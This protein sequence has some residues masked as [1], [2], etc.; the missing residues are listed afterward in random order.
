MAD[1]DL[2]VAVL[3]YKRPDEL[4][5]G[6]PTIIE[7]VIELNNSPQE[8]VQARILVVDNDPAGTGRAPVDE[9]GSPLLHY[10]LEPQPG[11]S[12]GRNRALRE[13]AHSS[14]LSFIDDDERPEE[15]WLVPLI[16]TWRAT[17]AAAVMGRVVSSFESP[18]D[19][20]VAAG[21]FFRR[22]RMRT[23]TEISVAAAGN[24]LLDMEQIRRLAVHFDDSFG[25]TGG[26]D[27]LFTRS[28]V[29]R[30][31]RMVWC[32]ESVAT[33]FV[34]AERIS[35]RW[36]LS[37]AWSH[38]NSACLVRLHLAESGVRRQLARVSSAGGGLARMAAGACRYG[39]GLLTVSYRDQARGLRT[40]CRGAGF[41]MGAM[42]LEFHEY[43]RSQRL[44]DKFLRRRVPGT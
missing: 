16:R 15:E 12:A 11:I 13:A 30:G 28:L 35:R 27:T 9:I 2:T 26:E 39:Y 7:H 29:R 23:G 4:R 3:T 38:G 33:D 36:V 19:D 24:L 32:D 34:P 6:L 8:A 21:E 18:P 14:L 42:G 1:V 25:L 40:A 31:G 5:R 43:S 37:R 17:G 44:R 20:W 10:V 22:R 41:L